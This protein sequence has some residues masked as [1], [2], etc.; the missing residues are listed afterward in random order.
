MPAGFPPCAKLNGGF[1]SVRKVSDCAC[2]VFTNPASASAESPARAVFGISSLPIGTLRLGGRQSNYDRVMARLKMQRVEELCRN[3]VP[4][5]AL[6]AD[7]PLALK[8]K[9]GVEKK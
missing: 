3:V 2:A 5:K 6:A 1:S 9:K 8:D 4:A 7:A